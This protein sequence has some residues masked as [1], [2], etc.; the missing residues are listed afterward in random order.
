MNITISSDLSKDG[1]TVTVDGKTL[2]NVHCIDFDMYH[3]HDMP[4]S[5]YDTMKTSSTEEAKHKFC[6][7]VTTKE[8]MTDGTEKCLIYNFDKC[9]DGEVKD[10]VTDA[11]PKLD[12]MASVIKDMMLGNKRRTL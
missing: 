1:T 9:D 3:F 10:S 12:E 8:Q 6:V 11:T 5:P 4:L 2:K 7:R